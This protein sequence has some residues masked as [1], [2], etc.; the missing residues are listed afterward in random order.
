MKEGKRNLVIKFLREDR[1]GPPVR[2][3][4]VGGSPTKVS[5]PQLH[6]KGNGVAMDELVLSVEGITLE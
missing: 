6:A 4:L 2:W 5:C 3:K 1:N